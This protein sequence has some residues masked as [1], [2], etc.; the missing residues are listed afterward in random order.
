MPTGIPAV[1]QEERSQ[2][3]NRKLAMSR[4]NELL[5]QKENETISDCRNSRWNHHNKLERG[6][7]VR[8]FEGQDFRLKKAG[9]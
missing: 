7:P 5:R 3:L 1:A 6:N 8:V 4:L 9:R 2:H